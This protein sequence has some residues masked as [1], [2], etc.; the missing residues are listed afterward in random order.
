MIE[1]NKHK[2][3]APFDGKLVTVRNAG[4]EFILQANNG[5]K[6]LLNL[7]FE[8]HQALTHRSHIA[9]INTSKVKQGQ[10]IAYFDLREL[11]QPLLA[12]LTILN[13]PKNYDV[14]Y[15]LNHV[16]AGEDILLTLTKK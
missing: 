5:L 4:T 15:S 7:Y 3:L 6:V 12:S 11:K 10:Q 9:Q 1:L 14:F 2:I 8:Q 16:D 13:A